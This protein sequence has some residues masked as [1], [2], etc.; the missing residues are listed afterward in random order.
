MGEREKQQKSTLKR[1]KM[2]QMAEL[3]KNSAQ[4]QLTEIMDLAREHSVEAFMTI[5]QIMREA[6]D[7]RLALIAAQY[8]CDR[9]HGKPA[10]AVELGGKDGGAIQVNINITRSEDADD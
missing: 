10:Q 6:D 5:V 1:Q 2:A 8:I 3:R 4:R 7:M 9:G